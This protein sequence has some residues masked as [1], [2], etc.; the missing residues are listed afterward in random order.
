MA[1]RI[2]K[3][4]IGRNHLR[5]LPPS[6]VL[7]ALATLMLWVVAFYPHEP[8]RP[9][10][11]L[12]T[13]QRTQVGIVSPRSGFFASHAASLVLM[14]SFGAPPPIASLVVDSTYWH[15][16]PNLLVYGSCQ[17]KTAAA[18]FPVISII[19]T[20]I[21]TIIKAIK[22]PTEYISDLLRR[23]WKIVVAV[24]IALLIWLGVRGLHTRSK[25]P[26]SP[27]IAQETQL[28]SGS[29]S[30][31][32][33][34]SITPNEPPA[35]IEISR[36]QSAVALLQTDLASVWEE[37]AHLNFDW[38]EAY[39]KGELDEVDREIAESHLELCQ[40]CTDDVLDLRAFAAEVATYPD[41][42]YA[43][44]PLPA[45]WEK[46]L[47]ASGLPALA[48]K[49][50][51][52]FQ[53]FPLSLR[54]AGAVAIGALVLLAAVRWLPALRKLSESPQIVK[55]TP[56][57]PASPDATIPL[58]KD[59]AP[60]RD[61]AGLDAL[62]LADQQKVK[63]VLTDRNIEISTNLSD[64]RSPSSPRM[65]GSQELITLESPVGIVVTSTR[66]VF[67]WRGLSGATNYRVVIAYP[68]SFQI[69]A[70]SG[71]LSDT[72]WQPNQPL[73]RGQV[74]EWQV[75][76]QGKGISQPMKFKVLDGARADELDRV[77]KASHDNHLLLGIL[78]ADAGALGEAAREFNLV[79]KT[80]ARFGI[81]RKLLRDVQAQI[82]AQK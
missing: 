38:L 55:Q 49:L 45:L 12:Q 46:L 27:N 44:T 54:I 34:V 5:H 57:P 39:I 23:L 19:K 78:Y 71:E 16:R 8:E 48:K 59:D 47:A 33:S 50:S 32:A 51:Q 76:S 29:P 64:L 63:A 41:K 43:P 74:Y 52:P 75:T 13:D 37:P 81:A 14:K 18:I 2:T 69:V 6:V 62:V 80:D 67:R 31:S 56:L 20:I 22:N 35:T 28:M 15:A 40:Q 36:L 4:F 17:E 61:I 79:P 70:E 25:P 72:K 73:K 9:T 3:R 42:E 7:S 10:A 82:R 65:G 21:K 66:P 1:D 26:E 60:R 77:K 53:A 24:I 30:A 58:P 68:R 11:P